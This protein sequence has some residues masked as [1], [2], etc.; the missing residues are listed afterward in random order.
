MKETTMRDIFIVSFG[1]I[2]V[3]SILLF[4]GMITSNIAAGIM[5]ALLI[6]AVCVSVMIADRFI[7]Q[8]KAAQEAAQKLDSAAVKSESPNPTVR[9]AA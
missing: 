8:R 9:H 2:L 3:L 1:S 5:N 7:L 4:S 6:A